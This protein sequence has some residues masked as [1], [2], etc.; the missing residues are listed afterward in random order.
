MARKSKPKAPKGPTQRYGIG[1]WYGLRFAGLSEADRILLANTKSKSRDC[2]YLVQVPSLGPKN[3]SLLCSKAS[4]VCSIRN[5]QEPTTQNPDITFGELTTTCP[6]RFLEHGIIIEHIAKTLLDTT[7][8]LFA[9]ELPFLRRPK[10][11]AASAAV[12]DDEQEDLELSFTTAAVDLGKEDVGRIDLVFVHP[13][14]MNK[15]CAVE[16]Q[17]VYFSGGEMSQDVTAIKAWSGNGIPMPA[18]IRRPDFRSSGPKR[19]MPQ[20]MIKVPTLRRWGKKM[21]VVVDKAF[22]GAMDVMVR[23]DHVSNCDIVWVVVRYDEVPGSATATLA[24]HETFFTTLEEAIIGLTAGSPTTLPEF[25]TKLQEK[26]K[27]VLPMP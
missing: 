2:P 11:A 24:I 26:I 25:E 7:A 21:V 5:F 23:A 18:G 6:I 20:L 16:M 10:S 8:P 14:D 4:G 12:A 15:W 3:K 19:L 13:D 27:P 1:E 9:K 17:A 22:F